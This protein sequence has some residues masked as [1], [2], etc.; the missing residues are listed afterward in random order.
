[1]TPPP[2]VK[3]NPEK[4]GSGRRPGVLALLVLFNCACFLKILRLFH[5]SVKN[6]AG[7][8]AAGWKNPYSY[9]AKSRQIT[10]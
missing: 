9:S 6:Y 3:I 4:I 7:F 1:M 5:D 10:V 8:V 2:L